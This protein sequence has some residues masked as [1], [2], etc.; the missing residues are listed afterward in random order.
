VANRGMTLIEIM[1][2]ITIVAILAVG[3]FAVGSYIDTQLKIERTKST[4][5][6]LVAALDQ[7]FDFYKSFPGTG[8]NLHE[9]LSLAP[10]SKKIIDQINR[11]AMR[12]NAAGKIEFVDAW[13]SK[14]YDGDLRYKYEIDEK[15]NFPVITSAG[16]DKIFGMDDP[17]GAADDISSKGL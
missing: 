7:Y 17:N 15:W 4:I 14:D 13:H 11:K 1:V 6:M 16:P 5:N 8:D 10:D 3:L 12:K 2:S 9:R